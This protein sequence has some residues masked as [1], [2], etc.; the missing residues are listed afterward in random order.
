[1]KLFK[2]IFLGFLV[3]LAGCDDKPQTAAQVISAAFTSIDIPKMRVDLASS[4]NT[5]VVPLNSV[6][7][8][9]EES[10]VAVPVSAA[11]SFVVVFF[12]QTWLTT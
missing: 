1:M 4:L 10:S 5:T 11:P 12:S 9:G 3:L 7:P 6:T 2:V 8:Y